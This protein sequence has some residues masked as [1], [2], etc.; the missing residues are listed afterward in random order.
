MQPRSAIEDAVIAVVQPI[1][2]ASGCTLFDVVHK[3]GVLRVTIDK[4]GGIDLEVI[5][6]VSPLVSDA[7][8]AA[9][10]LGGQFTLE[11]SSPG[12]ERPLRTPDQIQASVGTLVAV[13]MN[14]SFSG[15]R[16]RKGTLDAADADGLVVDG[17]RLG[18]DDVIEAHTVFEWGPSAKPSAPKRHPKDTDQTS[19]PDPDIPDPHIEEPTP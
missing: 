16:R 4:P 2:E 3:P 12:L 1:V 7:I 17:L 13:K 19:V 15:E 5:G 8:D 9:D 18:Y 14:A 10:P 6:E 11:V